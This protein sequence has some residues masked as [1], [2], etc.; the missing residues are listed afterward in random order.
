ME[1]NGMNEMRVEKWR[2]EIFGRAN[3]KKIRGKPTQ[4][5]SNTKPIWLDRDA[6]SGPLP[7]A[8]RR[9]LRTFYY[10][11]KYSWYYFFRGL[12]LRIYDRNVFLFLGSILLVQIQLKTLNMKLMNFRVIQR[13]STTT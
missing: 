11:L 1:R 4:T 2:N 3:R 9:S 13:F 8:P 5:P 7:P 12:Q 10:D 6:N